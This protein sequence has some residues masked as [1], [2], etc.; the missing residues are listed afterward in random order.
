M[1]QLKKYLSNLRGDVF[2][3]LPMKESEIGGMVNHLREYMETLIVNM[4]GA[5]TTYPTLS[6]EKRFL[7]V[8]NN[9]QYLL[10]QEVDFEQW[11][12][13]ILRSTRYI[14]DLFLNCGGNADDE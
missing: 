1:S 13:I 11:R 14:D 6:N 7:Y 8:I 9:L 3:L 5:S 2:K 12:K 10:K 4:S